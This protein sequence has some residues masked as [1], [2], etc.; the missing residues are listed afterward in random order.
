MHGSGCCSVTQSGLTLATPRTTERQAS[1]SFT[2]FW[3]LLNSWPLSHCC[4]PTTFSSVIPSPPAFNLS[5]IGVFSNELALHIRWPKYWNFSLS[6]SPRNEYSESIS[7]KIDWFNL[8]AVQGTLRVFLNTTVQ[9]HHSLALSSL[10]SPN[11]TFRCDYWKYH[12]FD[13]GSGDRHKSTH[14]SEQETGIQPTFKIRNLWWHF[15][16]TQ[17]VELMD[18]RAGED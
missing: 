2:I 11:L 9:K 4:H 7:F 12:S 6:T 10:Y 14:E 17:R 3:S 5:N 13:Y 16:K 18:W 1:L 8:F 15:I